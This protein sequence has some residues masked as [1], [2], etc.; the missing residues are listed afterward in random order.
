MKRTIIVCAALAAGILA[1]SAQAGGAKHAAKDDGRAAVSLSRSHVP[2]IYQQ[3]SM[4]RSEDGEAKLVMNPFL[5]IYSA[6]GSF[7]TILAMPQRTLP[8]MIT[9]SG[10][11][12]VLSDHQLV[13]SIGESIYDS[14]HAGD[15]NT[16]IYT[17]RGDTMAFLFLSGD[18]VGREAWYAV[19]RPA[20]AKPKRTP[21]RAKALAGELEGVWQLCY[22]TDGGRCV[23]API[24][25]IFSA[26]GTFVTVNITSRGGEARVSSQGSYAVRG[27]GEYV[28][29]VSESATDPELVGVETVFD[30]TF[31][32]DNGFYMRVSYTLPGRDGAVTEEWARVLG[33]ELAQKIL[34]TGNM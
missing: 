9:T 23:Y 29:C 22:R 5:K 27:A 33:T 32:D 13:E 11:Y 3:C 12:R 7:Y 21:A 34:S 19:C 16:I 18:G 8:A 14:H 15:E 28:E 31:T 10:S 24:Y 30:C 1:A 4:V 25:K 2:G 20:A 17:L 6:D 26:D